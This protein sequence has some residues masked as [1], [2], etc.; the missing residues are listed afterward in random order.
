MFRQALKDFVKS[1][2]LFRTIYQKGKAEGH[3]YVLDSSFNPPHDGHFHLVTS[4]FKTFKPGHI[5]LLLSINNADKPPTP[6]SFEQRLDMMQRFGENLASYSICISKMSKFVD[7][8]INIDN[9][10]IGSKYYLLGFDT[11]IRLLN[12]KYYSEPIEIALNDFMTSNKFVCL[13]RDDEFEISQQVK[14]LSDLKEGK[15]GLPDW[16]DSIYLLPN[17]LSFVSS[18]GIR[19]CVQTSK[20]VE[21][22]PHSVKQYIYENNLYKD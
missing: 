19:K 21:N 8:S 11:L 16:S 22:I 4:A 3:I 15:L 2:E 5:V 20:S 17:N 6:A 13:V 18:S 14:Y 7:K 1:S 12:P 9:Q 10:F